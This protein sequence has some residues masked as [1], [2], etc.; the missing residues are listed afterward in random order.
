VFPGAVPGPRVVS[1]SD[2]LSVHH[3]FQTTAGG[4]V[5]HPRLSDPAMMFAGLQ[6]RVADDLR[7]G[8]PPLWNPDLFGGAPLLADQQS[9]AGSPVVWLKAALPDGAA[10]DLGVWWV[11]VWTG[12]GTALLARALRCRPWAAAAAG[13]AAMT[14]PFLS[15]WLLHPLSAT[16]CWIPWVLWTMETRRWP[17]L[18]LCAAGMLCAGHPETAFTGGLFAGGWW[19]L[20][21]RRWQ[22]ALALAAGALMAAPILLPFLEQ[23]QRSTTLAAHGNNTLAPS[24]L[25]DLLWPGWWGHPVR[26]DFPEGGVWADGQL[27]PGLGALA[28]ALASLRGARRL[29]LGLWAAWALCLVASVVDLPGPISVARAGSMGAWFL[30][31][32]AGLGADRLPR[33]WAPAALALIAATGIHARWLDQG[34]LSAE[35]HAPTPAPWT[36]ELREVLRCTGDDLAAGTPPG[37]GRVLGLGWALQPNTGALVGLRDLRGHDLPISRDTERFM[38]ALDPRLVRPWFS[39]GSPPPRALLDFAATRVL[40]SPEPLDG[41][42]TPLELGDAPL[43]AYALDLEAPRAWLATSA[44]PARNPDEGLSRVLRDPDARG[45]PPVENLTGQWPSA[46]T[47][48]PLTVLE[49]GGARVR[50]PLGG[51]LPR[52]VVVLADAWAPGWTADVDGVDTPCLRAGG[53]FRAV[54]VEAGAQEVTLRYRP[55]GWV[56]GLWIALI[57]LLIAAGL[58]LGGRLRPR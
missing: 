42:Y 26:G 33:R 10:R 43:F 1:A 46:G 58:A 52:G 21:S 14:G 49:D 23:L 13:A 32:A 24:A 37:C 40:L 28:L 12:L 50:I 36:R 55:A 41:D 39:V 48:T 19:L 44:Q 27:H 16:A 3:A 7:R 56:Y 5:R 57:G 22:G 18:A 29:T 6:Q 38:A 11:M 2:H 54:V 17:W 4:G 31:L 15:V 51:E 8:R 53:H 30:A 34:T 45:R 25:W 20:R 47:A 35:A 9:M